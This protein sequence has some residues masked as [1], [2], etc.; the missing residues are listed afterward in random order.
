MQSLAQ[1]RGTTIMCTIHQPSSQLFSMFQQVYY[2]YNKMELYI[3]SK[4]FNFI[5]EKVCLLAE[6]RVAFCGTPEQALDFFAE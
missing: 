6:G 3:V 1:Q 5:Y 2:G 4:M